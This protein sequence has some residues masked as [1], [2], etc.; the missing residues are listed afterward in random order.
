ML[1]ANFL[2]LRLLCSLLLFLLLGLLCSLLFFYFLGCYAHYYFFTSRSTM[3]NT[4]FLLLELL[5]S[6]LLSF[7]LH[8][9]HSTIMIHCFFGEWQYSWSFSLQG[10]NI[11]IFKTRRIPFSNENLYSY[12]VV[13]NTNIFNFTWKNGNHLR[14]VMMLIPL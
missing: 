5:Y 12:S 3:L 13:Y 9:Q 1:I 6:L 8:R 2:L 11:I 7:K 10:K 14:L 4:T